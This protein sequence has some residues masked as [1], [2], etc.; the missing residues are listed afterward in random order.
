MEYDARSR[1]TTPVEFLNDKYSLPTENYDFDQP[2]EE[3]HYLE[4]DEVKDEIRDN[5]Y[6]AVVD[7]VCMAHTLFIACSTL[8]L[9][10]QAFVRQE[11]PSFFIQ[12]LI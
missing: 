6:D 2:P 1:S 12:S 4:L 5:D 11:C 7:T 3:D 9:L 10:E 8:L